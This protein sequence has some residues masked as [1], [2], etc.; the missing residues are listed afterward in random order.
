MD[1]WPALEE[2]WTRQI[3]AVEGEGVNGTDSYAGLS[4]FVERHGKIELVG[5]SGDQ[6]GF[7]SHLYVHRPSK[8]GYIIAF[9]TDVSSVRDPRHTTRAVDA[10]VRDAII[11]E[12]WATAP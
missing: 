8:S 9:N 1:G 10:D 7:I 3:R 11:R 5:H 4:F 12:F 6:N 2:M